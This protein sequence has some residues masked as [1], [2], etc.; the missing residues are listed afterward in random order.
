M[1]YYSHDLFVKFRW[2]ERGLRELFATPGKLFMLDFDYI[3]PA[4]KP[5]DIKIDVSG[6][7]DLVQ[8]L[9]FFARDANSLHKD[10]T[11]KPIVTG[12]EAIKLFDAVISCVYGDA[13][14][15]DQEYQQYL[16]GTQAR[17][18]PRLEKGVRLIDK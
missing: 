1:T 15:D 3:Q 13:Y 18:R 16:T 12:D 9:L 7:P 2:C 14:R 4:I 5:D 6:S 17:Y 11:G 10:P 8:K